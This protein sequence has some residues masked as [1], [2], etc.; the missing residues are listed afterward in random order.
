[1]ADDEK[2]LIAKQNEGGRM[3]FK[4]R[5]KKRNAYAPDDYLKVINPKDYNQMALLFEDLDL[6][7]G[8]PIEKSFREYQDRKTKGFPF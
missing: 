4:I 1:M 7:I 3:S 5:T 2:V 8:A 6:L